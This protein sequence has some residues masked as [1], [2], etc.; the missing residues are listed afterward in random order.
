M[1]ESYARRIE[2]VV[3]AGARGAYMACP[4]L[5]AILLLKGFRK[6]YDLGCWADLLLWMIEYQGADLV[7][8]TVDHMDMSSWLNWLEQLRTILGE[9]RSHSQAPILAAGL[10]EWSQKLK[11]ENSKAISALDRE[12]IPESF[13]EWILLA[14]EEDRQLV[15]QMLTSIGRD[16][17]RYMMTLREFLSGMKDIDGIRPGIWAAVA[18]RI[19]NGED[20]MV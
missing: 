15:A 8:S 11:E 13:R 19:K 9:K 14:R 2:A 20:L 7:Q 17:E 4:G 12:H 1:E 5:A 6:K 16:E 18:V 10:H 3:Q